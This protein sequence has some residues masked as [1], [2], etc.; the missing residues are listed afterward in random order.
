MLY[1]VVPRLISLVPMTFASVYD[2]IKGKEDGVQMVSKLI[3]TSLSDISSSVD[4]LT[5]NFEDKKF[6]SG[7]IG[8]IGGDLRLLFDQ[9]TDKVNPQRLMNL[10]TFGYI[11]SDLSKIVDP[12]IKFQKAFNL[13]S[14]DMKNFA[15]DF[16]KI[17][18]ENFEKFSNGVISSNETNSV[19]IPYS[20]PNNTSSPTDIMNTVIPGFT[21][22]IKSA[23]NNNNPKDNSITTKNDNETLQNNYYSAQ[24]NID[25]NALA[26][27]IANKLMAGT[28]M[29]SPSD[30]NQWNKA[31]RNS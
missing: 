25:I 12:F 20:A 22:S 19:S 6:N 3:S 11:I 28:L 1:T 26:D 14:I 23:L 18:I 10:R 5:K 4:G 13:F 21:E 15:N 24:N 31:F 29:V 7:Y 16:S 17:N 8:R 9:V 27:L 2:K 30:I